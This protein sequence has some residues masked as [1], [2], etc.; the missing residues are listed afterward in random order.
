MKHTNG[1]HCFWLWIIL[2]LRYVWRQVT[3]VEICARHILLLIT[4]EKI[5][6][7]YTSGLVCLRWFTPIHIGT[8]LSDTNAAQQKT[9][10]SFLSFV[11]F[12]SLS[13]GCLWYKFDRAV[14]NCCIYYMH[15]GCAI[16]VTKFIFSIFIFNR[17][18]TNRRH[19]LYF[20]SHNHFSSWLI[21]LN[22]GYFLHESRSKT[23][24]IPKVWI[25][26]KSGTK[27]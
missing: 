18:W 4:N 26:L 1:K 24:S 7:V 10:C 12:G 16:I 15:F 8:V 6:L 25:D 5:P 11:C 27:I 17:I 20:T 22:F 23:F 9:I 13:Y 19:N 2:R 21:G 14:S 3:N